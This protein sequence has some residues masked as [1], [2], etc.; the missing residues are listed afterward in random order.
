MNDELRRITKLD[1]ALFLIPLIGL[2]AVWSFLT[3]SMPSTDDGMLF[4][5]RVVEL[6]RCLRHGVLPL[7]WAPDFGYGYGY[8]LFNYYA[9]L[10][11]YIAEFWHLV[12]LD[13]PQAIAAATVSAFFVSGWGA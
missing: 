8:P 11:S 10:S 12:G 3:Q 6:D 5:L 9:S 13:F 1:P 7:R 4:M 2:V